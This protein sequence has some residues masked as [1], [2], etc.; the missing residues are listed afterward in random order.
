MSVILTTMKIINSQSTN[1]NKLKNA[2]VLNSLKIVQCDSEL[3][4]TTLDISLDSS[5]NFHIKINIF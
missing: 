1:G 5:H 3:L 4:A 2:I